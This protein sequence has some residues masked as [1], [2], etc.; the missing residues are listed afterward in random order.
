[1]KMK[2]DVNLSGNENNNLTN[3]LLIS[4]GAIYNPEQLAKTQNIWGAISMGNYIQ[5]LI[6]FFNMIS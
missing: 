3:T 1:M 4:P 2:W 6:Q 5:S